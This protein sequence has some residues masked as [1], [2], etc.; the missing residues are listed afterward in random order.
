V[1]RPPGAVYLPNFQTGQYTSPADA[2]QR[3]KIA[4]E[5]AGCALKYA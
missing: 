3:V 1:L 4:F 2:L 5:A